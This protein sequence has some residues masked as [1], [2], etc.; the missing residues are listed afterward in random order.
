MS[1]R[2]LSADC[3][4]QY[5]E[6]IRGHGRDASAKSRTRSTTPAV[7]WGSGQSYETLVDSRQYV[8]SSKTSRDP[9]SNPG[10]TISVAM[11]TD[12]DLPRGWEAMSATE[13]DAWFK[14]ER[15]RRRAMKQQT[16]FSHKA[17]RAQER[18][19]RR[20]EARNTAYIGDD[21]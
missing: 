18:A 21:P 7:P 5:L 16:T 6:E 2:L 17:E 15:A 4:T 12:Y 14:Q 20:T 8:G 11:P 3:V 13:L 10:G 19:E 9:G 1:P